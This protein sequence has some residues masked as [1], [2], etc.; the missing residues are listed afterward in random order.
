MKNTRFA[1]W[2]ILALTALLAIPVLAGCAPVALASDNLTQ[3][4]AEL[5]YV[6]P[7]TELKLTPVSGLHVTNVP[8]RDID[9]ATYRLEI[10][11]L[12]DNPLSLTYD[13]VRSFPAVSHHPMLLCPGFF[14]DLAEWKGVPVSTL[15]AKAGLKPGAGAVKVRSLDGYESSIPLKNIDPDEVYLAWE[16]NGET[17]PVE[18]G[19]PLRLVVSWAEGANWSKWVQRLEVIG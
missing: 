16:V 7:E 4:P 9:I 14:E 3:P 5:D 2:L 6:L 13:E 19:Y 11:G 8:P 18:H 15:L 12:V 10:T 1:P 17:L